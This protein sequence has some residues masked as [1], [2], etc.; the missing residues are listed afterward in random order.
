MHLN[1]KQR[2]EIHKLIEDAKQ[3]EYKQFNAKVVNAV[4]E[5]Q[6]GKKTEEEAYN[7]IYKKVIKNEHLL[8]QRYADLD[9][10][11]SLRTLAE[12]FSD[13]IVNMHDFENLDQFVKKEIY[14]IVGIN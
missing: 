2:T 14:K 8:V 7:K 4:Q 12:V 3:T 10:A 11:K 9:D 5:L 1:D 13:D 6:T